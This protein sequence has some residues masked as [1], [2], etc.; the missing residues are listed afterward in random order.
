MVDIFGIQIGKAVR[1]EVG[2]SLPGNFEIEVEC[3]FELH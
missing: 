1:G 2:K 3:A